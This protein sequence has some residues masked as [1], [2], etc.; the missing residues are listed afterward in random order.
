M[1]G[2]VLIMTTLP[3]QQKVNTGVLTT[4]VC[5][6]LL[7]S[8]CPVS[9]AL[10]SYLSK[11]TEE[12][13]D[14]CVCVCECVRARLCLLHGDLGHSGMKN[15]WSVVLVIKKRDKKREGVYGYVLEVKLSVSLCGRGCPA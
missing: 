9:V 12:I 2:S 5:L 4:L 13:K 7:S 11:G 10:T 1:F 8:L 15:T 6:Q 14:V 3:C